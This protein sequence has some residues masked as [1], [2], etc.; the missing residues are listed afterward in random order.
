MRIGLID[1]DGHSGFPNLALMKLSAWHKTQGDSVEWYS[2]M[3]SGHV[4][5]VYMS[6]VFTFT[7]DFEYYVDADEII[8]AGTGYKDYTTVL[9]EEI[10]NT[11]PD[12]LI[13]PNCDFAVGFLTR[14]CIRNCPW[15]VV[16]KKEGKIHGVNTWENIKRPGSKRILFLDNN[17]LACDH[18][19]HQIEQMGGGASL[20]IDFNQG[21]DA[22]L[23]DESVAKL[24][25]RIKWDMCLRISCD[26]SGM[27][28]TVIKAIE[29]LIKNG[30]RA[31]DI[32]VYTLVQDIEESYQRIMAIANTGAYP[33]AQPYRDFEGGE[34]TYE[35]KQLA[36]WCNRKEM[37]FSQTWEEYKRQKGIIT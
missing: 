23:I 21:L 32:F 13:Y 1:V 7:N 19:L 11:F 36:R 31:K 20:K 16:P 2:P 10:E 26:T 9:P 22:R 4:D 8:K 34:P 37:F 30:I 17:V 29:L 28:P 35:Q 5:R 14:G 18:G 24:L 33:F 27:I 6:K 15:C 12:Y 3:F 25:G